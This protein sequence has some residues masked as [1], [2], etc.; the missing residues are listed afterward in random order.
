VTGEATKVKQRAAF[1][2]HQRA[3]KSWHRD[4]PDSPSVEV[5]DREIRPLIVGLPIRAIAG[6]TGLSQAYSSR[7]RRGLVVP[8]PRHWP[9]L[10]ALTDRTSH[11]GSAE[12]SYPIPR[13]QS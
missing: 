3:L 12:L 1:L 9:A 7:I 5:Y 8:H 4:H 10:H 2:D 6:A 11:E 13:I